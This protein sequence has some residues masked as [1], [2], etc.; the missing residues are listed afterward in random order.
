MSEHQVRFVDN[1]KG[2]HL[3]MAEDDLQQDELVTRTT[4]VAQT[5]LDGHRSPDRTIAMER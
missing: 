1:T 5:I 3:P 2:G 4:P